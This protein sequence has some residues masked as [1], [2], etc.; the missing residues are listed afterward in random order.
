MV[1]RRHWAIVLLSVACT[2]DPCK[3][4]APSFRLDVRAPPALGARSLEVV[5]TI[6]ADRRARTFNLADQLAD[7]ETSLAV[8][9]EPPPAGDFTLGV[10]VTAFG[11]ADASGAVLGTSERSFVGTPDG[12]NAFAVEIGGGAGPDGGTF[13]CTG[14]A[15]CDERCGTGPCEGQCSGNSTCTLVCGTATECRLRCL[16][17]AICHLRCENAG[18]CEIVDCNATAC[19]DGSLACRRACP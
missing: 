5:V 6:G 9:V 4:A 10:T 18:A 3:E 13:T 1:P 19:A 12:C 15:T 17:N 14:A 16:G 11:G 7:G 2:A 8:I